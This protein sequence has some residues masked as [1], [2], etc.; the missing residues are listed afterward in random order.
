MAAGVL[1]APG[2]GVDVDDVPVAKRSTRATMQAAPGNTVPHC[3][4]ERF[5]V[6]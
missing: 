3:L 4:K 5:V 2:L 1:L 6:V